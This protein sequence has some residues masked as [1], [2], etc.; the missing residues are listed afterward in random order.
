MTRSLLP[1]R[2][3]HFFVLQLDFALIVVTF[4]AFCLEKKSGTIFFNILTFVRKKMKFWFLNKDKP[5]LVENLPLIGQS[6]Y[7]VFA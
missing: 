3:M 7:S 6:D 1:S 4:S 5:S 2:K